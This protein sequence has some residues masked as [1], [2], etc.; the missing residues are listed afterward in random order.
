M[1]NTPVVPESAEADPV[2]PYKAI[3]A[4]LAPALVAFLDVLVDNGKHDEWPSWVLLLL[5]ALL[6]G[7]STYVVRNP[8]KGERRHNTKEKRA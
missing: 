7:V 3:V 6:A 4:L 1:S 2:K 8:K 5:A